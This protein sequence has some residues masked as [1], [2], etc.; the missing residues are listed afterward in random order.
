MSIERGSHADIQATVGAGQIFHQLRKIALEVQTEGQ[1]IR[2]HYNA[3]GALANQRIDG[4][5]E[6]GPALFEEGGL[7]KIEA[8]LEPNG[9]RD[10][11]HGF[12]G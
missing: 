5:G 2:Q 9:L 10:P 11:A 7:D 1:K 8:A 6:V 3:R 4:G 12:I